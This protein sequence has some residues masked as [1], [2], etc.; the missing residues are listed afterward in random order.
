MYPKKT[1]NFNYFLITI[2]LFAS[3]NSKSKNTLKTTNNIILSGK[4][5][6]KNDNRNTA[7]L[8]KFFF[9]LQKR[10]I[11]SQSDI[12]PSNKNFKIELQANSPQLLKLFYEDVFVTPN[13]SMSFDIIIDTETGTINKWDV[14]GKYAGNYLYYVK[15]K[16]NGIDLPNAEE[17]KNKWDSYKLNIQEYKNKR[18]E[19]LEEFSKRNHISD[20]FR[21]T[22]IDEITYTYYSA[23]MKPIGIYKL[24]VKALPKK[25]LEE[26]NIVS[27]QD[28]TKLELTCFGLALMD[29]FGYITMAGKHKFPSENHFRDVYKAIYQNFKGK[30][31]DFLLLNSLQE[32]QANKPKDGFNDFYKKQ[33]QEYLSKFSD[34][35]FKEVASKINFSRILD[36]DIA[37]KLSSVSLLHYERKSGIKFTDLLKRKKK[38][39]IDFWASWCKPC[40]N[41]MKNYSKIS[42]IFSENDVDYILISLDDDIKKWDTA[43][44]KNNLNHFESY[45]MNDSKDTKIMNELFNLSFIPRYV[46][47]SSDGKI[48]N[49]EAPRP[50][51][52]SELKKYF[53]NSKKI[54]QPPPLSSGPP[55]PPP[56]SSL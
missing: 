48:E 35:E 55:P 24:D 56:P 7:I 1:F 8:E 4:A 31:A 11:I 45:L 13:D 22:V 43:I 30:I 18:L 33:Y 51:Q 32:Y 46:I 6:L 52:S 19:H 10:E 34:S 28:D 40:L 53:E 26:I 39:Y 25:Y 54:L 29:Y 44:K 9:P 15:L 2:I 42:K 21:K 37:S 50:S 3:C 27:F 12:E 49:F 41:E 17:Y 23:L 38:I 14:Q 20:A 5:N 36:L 16:E 47:I